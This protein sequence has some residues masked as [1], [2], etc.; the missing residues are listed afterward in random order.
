M[1]LSPTK[2]VAHVEEQ[3]RARLAGQQVEA[4]ALFQPKSPLTREMSKRDARRLAKRT[5]AFAVTADAV[6]VFGLKDRGYTNVGRVEEEL[7]TWPRAG[8]TVSTGR[9]RDVLRRGIDEPNIASPTVLANVTTAD[10]WAVTLSASTL[11]KTANNIN[12]AF[13]AVLQE[14]P[15]AQP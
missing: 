10:G 9:G 11:S 1:I 2:Y 15:A 14:R 4:I 3:L 7:A 5:A 6:H 8:L 12:E 13:V